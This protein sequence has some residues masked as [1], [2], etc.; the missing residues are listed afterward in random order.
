MRRVVLWRWSA[1]AICSVFLL[2]P[3]VRWSSASSFREPGVHDMRSPATP[4]LRGARWLFE[5]P[6]RPTCKTETDSDI[7]TDTHTYTDKGHQGI[8]Q[9]HPARAR[10][11]Q[12]AEKH[13]KR[14]HSKQ[15]GGPWERVRRPLCDR[16]AWQSTQPHQRGSWGLR[17]PGTLTIGPR[18]RPIPW[19]NKSSSS[20]PSCPTRS[21]NI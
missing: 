6:L 9:R 1:H 10:Q 3:T 4:T 16:L 11:V 7:Q 13:P 15:G 19:R 18:S 2:A 12:R 17:R 5:P 14:R 8:I 20:T 21:S